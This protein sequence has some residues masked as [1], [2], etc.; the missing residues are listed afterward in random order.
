[1]AIRES[2]I[3][4]NELSTR[5]IK[6]RV[7]DYDDEPVPGSTISSLKLTL[8]NFEDSVVIN[9]RMDVEL[10]SF[11]DEEGWF[12]WEMRP[13]DNI[14]CVPASVPVWEF[15]KHILLLQLVGLG[16]SPP[17]ENVE[18]EIFVKNL[19]LVP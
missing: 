9:N 13:E 16:G 17:G 18:K 11:L 7:R 15:E 12:T 19:G 8:V 2:Q 5:R 14:I 1:M 6:F 3:T 4:A 10:I